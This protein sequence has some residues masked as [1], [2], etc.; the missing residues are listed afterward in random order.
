[1]QRKPPRCWGLREQ[2]PLPGRAGMCGQ[3]LAS[4]SQ[5]GRRWESPAR[6]SCCPGIEASRQGAAADAAVT[7]PGI[8]A[9]K[10]SFYAI[11]PIISARSD[12]VCLNLLCFFKDWRCFDTQRIC[13]A[14]QNSL[15][16]GSAGVIQFCWVWEIFAY[17]FTSTQS[18]CF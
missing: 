13:P 6:P 9:A 7:Q 5:K 8:T 17:F 10:I 2:R 3:S 4:A 12:V 14:L 16:Q 18:C 15:R 1:M 11:Q